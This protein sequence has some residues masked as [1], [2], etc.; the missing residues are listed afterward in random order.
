M[1]IYKVTNLINNKIYIGQTILDLKT[2][3]RQ[4]ENSYKYGYRYAFSNAINKYGKENFKWEIL[5]VASNIEDLNERES[6]YIKKYKS[7]TTQN[8]YNLKGGGK[9]SFLT[10]DVKM[11]ISNSQMGKLN[12]MYGK[13]GV[14]NK[15]SKRVKNITTGNIYESA[16][17]CAL[18]ENINLSHICAVCRGSRGSTN[19][20]IYRYLDAKGEIIEPN[21]VSR[22]KNIP[23]KNIDTGEIFN[24]VAE[25]EIFYKGKKS[26]NLNKVCK[27]QR[28]KFAGFRWKY[29]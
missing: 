28:K 17:L 20:N 18:K 16:S 15:T 24:S 13:K 11:K 21:S 19:N 6:Y 1:I 3:K 10:E 2:R 9:N 22:I 26:G 29:L 23:V 7:L 8:G 4:H 12:H 27:G 5:Y 14:L 25:A